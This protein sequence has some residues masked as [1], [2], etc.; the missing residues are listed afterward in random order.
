[1]DRG[2]CPLQ[3]ATLHKQRAKEPAVG[4]PSIVPLL[5]SCVKTDLSCRAGNKFKNNCKIHSEIANLSIHI[6]INFKKSQPIQID[7][8]RS[9]FYLLVHRVIKWAPRHLNGNIPLL[10]STITLSLV[11]IGF[12]RYP[13]SALLSW[14]WGAGGLKF[15]QIRGEA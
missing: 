11:K 15:S 13:L 4:R 12:L 3:A 6:H 10:S 8:F 14:Y 2:R 9:F 5:H 1:M 7:D